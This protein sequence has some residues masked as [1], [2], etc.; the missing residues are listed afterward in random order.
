MPDWCCQCRGRHRRVDRVV[1]NSRNP[2]ALSDTA[3]LIHAIAICDAYQDAW[4]AARALLDGDTTV[5]QRQA[6][7]A[8][9]TADLTAASRRAHAILLASARVPLSSSDGM[10]IVVDLE[11]LF[12]PRKPG[13][14]GRLGA[15]LRRRRTR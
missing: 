9:I 7:V 8:K 11:A 4:W 14:W 2:D 10:A 1:T 3:K 5:E 13:R 15:T 12:G 6:G